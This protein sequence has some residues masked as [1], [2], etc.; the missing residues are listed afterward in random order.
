MNPQRVFAGLL[1]IALVANCWGA[2][3]QITTVSQ[4]TARAVVLANLAIADRTTRRFTEQSSTATR[5]G[6][7]WVWRAR[8]G[9]GHGDLEV[10]V[11]LRADGTA[12]TQVSEWSSISTPRFLRRDDP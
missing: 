1:V 12:D 4:A 5:D 9:Y 7:R 6:D 3:A 11:T 8:I 10:V 2:P